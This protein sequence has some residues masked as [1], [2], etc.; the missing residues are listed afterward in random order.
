MVNVRIPK[1]ISPCPI[2]EAISEVRF[3]PLVPTEAIFGFIYK[4]IQV[5]YPTV[6][7]LPIL[8]LPDFMRESDPTFTF[9]PHYKMSNENFIIQV[10]PRVLSIS[11]INDYIG[12]PIFSVKIF[13]LLK[14]ILQLGII[15]DIQ[16]ISL[17][18]INFFENN[19][20]NISNLKYFLRDDFLGQFGSMI[21]VEIPSDGLMNAIRMGNNAEIKIDADHILK[22]SIL[23]I[24]TFR[25]G[26]I[27]PDFSEL[28]NI[29]E[30]CHETEKHL[31][32]KI[33]KTDFISGLNPEY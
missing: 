21:T 16:R 20:F 26:P 29:V 28:V 13:E 6:D 2:I 9:A 24:D 5:D 27:R 18:Y 11:N 1:K 12:W 17:R 31:F 30:Q 32:Y 3:E 7:K 14:K 8:Q 23:D 4:E 10:G 19:I 15:G 22:G 25:P 33:L